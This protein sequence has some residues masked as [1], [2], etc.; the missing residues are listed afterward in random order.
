MT[1]LL[2]KNAHV[3]VTMDETRREIHDGALLVRDHV[4][5][6]VGTTAEIVARL[7]H[8]GQ[9]PDET[10]N[11][12]DHVLLPGLINTHHHMSQ[13]L[14]RAVPTMQNH[15]LMGWLYGLYKYLPYLTPDMI[16]VSAKVA[17]AELILSG[18]TTSSDHLYVYPNG[19]RMDD[20]VRAAQEI[21]LRFHP[22]R[23]SVS[24]KGGLLADEHVESEAFIERDTIRL[25]DTYHQAERYGMVRV[26]VAPG[27]P[28]SVTHA[29]MRELARLARSYGDRGVHLH[30]HF[31]ETDYDIEALQ[32]Q[33]G[34]TPEQYLEEYEWVG[35]DVW[36]AHCVQI[37]DSGIALFSRTG[38]GVAH[39]PH[40]NARLGAGIAPV[41]KM[42]KAG[43]RVAL[44]VD[45]TASNDGG[46]IIAE[47]R[48]ALMLAR[49]GSR[50]A[51]AM[52]AREALEIGT[53]GGAA[54]LGRDDVGVLAPNMAADFIA[55]HLKQLGFAGALH[56]PVAAVVLCTPVSVDYSVINGRVIV[57]EGQLTTLELGA[58]IEQHNRYAA[59]L[60]A[61]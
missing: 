26:V 3:L 22:G 23:G 29:F 54:V 49:A 32:A 17:M 52:T 47:A 31:L 27:A 42:R 37:S 44:G 58:L 43:V 50:D 11:L 1:L 53:R 5:E 61:Q 14:L 10:L 33:L 6:A 40:S 4:I 51:A 46:H 20:E 16:Y 25:I 9:T 13:S 39:C 8:T 34:L 45:G 38:T 30:T 48:Q 18:C 56:D 28:F 55:I 36:H 35:D 41:P 24:I 7:Q 21:G 2:A 19:C 57:R 60:A 15:D 59:D 12:R